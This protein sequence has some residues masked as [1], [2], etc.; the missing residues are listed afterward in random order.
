MKKALLIG[1]PI[2]AIVV[3][4][5]ITLASRNRGVE[6]IAVEV[7]PVGRREVVQTVTATGKIQP[8]I[9]VNI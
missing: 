3:V 8:M 2:V 7:E 9:Q 4:A 5:G 6:G 1:L